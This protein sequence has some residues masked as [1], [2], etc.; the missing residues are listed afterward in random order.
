MYFSI[1]L[2]SVD[3]V[4]NSCIILLEVTHTALNIIHVN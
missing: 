3:E 1:A 2:L 4:Q